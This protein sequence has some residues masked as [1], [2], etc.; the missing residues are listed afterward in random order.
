M[1]RVK[2]V[3]NIDVGNPSLK[4]RLKVLCPAALTPAHNPS[5]PSCFCRGARG[6]ISFLKPR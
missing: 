5:K 4:P 6:E 3:D 1:H 2:S